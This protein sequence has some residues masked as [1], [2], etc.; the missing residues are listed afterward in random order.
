MYICHAQQRYLFAGY[1]D[2]QTQA[3][4]GSDALASEQEGFP[5]PGPP[6]KKRPRQYL[7]QVLALLCLVLQG[8]CISLHEHV[9][10]LLERQDEWWS[11]TCVN[12]AGRAAMSD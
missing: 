1:G 3:V 7:D 4:Q 5:A 10:A 12:S 2:R 8:N 9:E 6:R 11:L